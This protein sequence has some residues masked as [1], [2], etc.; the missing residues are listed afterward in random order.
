MGGSPNQIV[1]PE[2]GK[3]RMETPPGTTPL[4]TIG[5]AMKASGAA[6]PCGCGKSKHERPGAEAPSEES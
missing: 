3:V 4:P 1:C 5:M 2:C 6:G